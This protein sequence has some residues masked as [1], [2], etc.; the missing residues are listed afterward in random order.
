MAESVYAPVPYSRR[1]LLPV[2][3]RKRIWLW[4]AI[5]AASFVAIGPLIYEL[6]GSLLSV[7]L[8]VWLPGMR[9]NIRFPILADPVA[10]AL[11]L[12]SVT[13]G[14]AGYEI[15]AC[16]LIVIAGQVKESAPIFALLLYHSPLFAGCAALT[17]IL[18]ILIGRWFSV[19]S[20][21]PKI[22]H[23]FRSALA[24]HDPFDWAVMVLPWGLIPVLLLLAPTGYWTWVAAVSLLL[25]YGQLVMAQDTA[26]LYQWAA[27]AILLATSGLS[28][29]QPWLAGVLLLHPFLCVRYGQVA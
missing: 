27:P 22:T 17:T 23:P 26:R 20:E 25:A 21:N 1:W 9:F 13:A 24:K 2:L 10:F 15:M 4:T 8:L 7:W 14:I 19:P 3:L 18:A 12:G 16:L 6:T 28:I 11:V 29:P 5:S